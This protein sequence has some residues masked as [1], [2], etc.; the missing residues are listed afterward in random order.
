ML[1]AVR[2][3]LIFKIAVLLGSTCGC[4]VGCDVPHIVDVDWRLDYCIKV[5]ILKF[6]MVNFN[7]N[8]KLNCRDL[9]RVTVM[10]SSSC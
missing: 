6:N 1:F 4:R 5:F 3:C 7:I 9:R 10:M 8:L 2:N